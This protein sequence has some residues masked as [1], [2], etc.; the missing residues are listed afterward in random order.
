MYVCMLIVDGIWNWNFFIHICCFSQERLKYH[1]HRE[2]SRSQPTKYLTVII[3]GK[4]LHIPAY[5]KHC[6]QK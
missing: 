2:K 5:M 6:K 1:H 3:D 4:L